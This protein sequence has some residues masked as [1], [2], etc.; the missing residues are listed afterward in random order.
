MTCTQSVISFLAIL[1]PF[2][3]CLYLVGVMEDLSMRAFLRVLVGA[4]TIA[5]GTFL[6]CAIFGETL[7]NDLLGIHPAAMRV[8]GG[9]IFL[10]VGYTY[11]TKGYKTVEMLRGSIEEL[12]AAIALPFMIG[13]G[14]I[15]QSI[16]IGKSHDMATS[17]ILLSIAVGVTFVA[18]VA[19]KLLRDRMAG[20]RERL[21][22]RYV[23][24]M[25]RVNGLLIGAISVE[26][27]VVGV[28]RLWL[29]RP[30]MGL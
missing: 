24:I 1:N 21:F 13:A 12:P 17:A 25:S 2:A 27:V 5:L 7:L 11:V 14:T 23:N 6:A 18:V 10:M 26:M 9:A 29:I 15:T 8:F 22:D 16:L 4:C 19:F 3:L 30:D 28:H 20:P